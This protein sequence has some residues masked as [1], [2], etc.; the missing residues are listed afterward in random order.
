ML[1]TDGKEKN[2]ERKRNPDE[3]SIESADQEEPQEGPAVTEL[4]NVHT[5]ASV[6]LPYKDTNVNRNRVSPSLSCLRSK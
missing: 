6:W 2:S 3:I 5:P 1:E 4:G